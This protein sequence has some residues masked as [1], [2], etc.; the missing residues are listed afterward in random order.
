VA[1]RHRPR[2]PRRPAGERAVS[3]LAPVVGLYVTA[4]DYTYDPYYAPNEHRFV[5]NATVSLWW[6]FGLLGISFALAL[7]TWR[8]PR[9]GGWV[10]AFALFVWFV[11]LLAAG[12]G[13]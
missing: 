2:L 1:R 3:L 12:D 7:F 13:H 6:I 4:T 8:R 9:A 10:T 11:T 5:D